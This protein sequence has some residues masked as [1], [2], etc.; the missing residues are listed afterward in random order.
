MISNLYRVPRE[1]FVGT[2][3]KAKY[4]FDKAKRTLS[5][6]RKHLCCPDVDAV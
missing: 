3:A 2:G 5:E 6:V 4:D 1:P